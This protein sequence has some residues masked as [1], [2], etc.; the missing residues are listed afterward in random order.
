MGITRQ[1]NFGHRNKA[2]YAPKFKQHMTSLKN[3]ASFTKISRNVINSKPMY[4]KN[5][6][7]QPS[8]CQI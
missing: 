6:S 2:Y 7:E 4:S 5:F 1:H 8:L 3:N